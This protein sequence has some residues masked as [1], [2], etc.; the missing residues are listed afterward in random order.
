M[1]NILSYLLAL[2]ARP[3]SGRVSGGTRKRIAGNVKREISMKFID[4]IDV[5]C[6]QKVE[7]STFPFPSLSIRNCNDSCSS[8]GSSEFQGCTSPFAKIKKVRPAEKN[9]PPTK[10]K[11]IF[12]PLKESSRRMIKP[13]SC[14]AFQPQNAAH[15]NPMAEILDA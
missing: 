11:I 1:D 10:R 7:L 4:T 5:Y 8:K 15:A 6:Y 9:A 2:M 12:Q 3:K 14:V 13:M